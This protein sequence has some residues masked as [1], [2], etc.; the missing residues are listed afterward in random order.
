MVVPAA[1]TMKAATHTFETGCQLEMAEI[2]TVTTEH[3]QCLQPVQHR[4]AM[5]E[6]ADLCIACSSSN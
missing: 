2:V 1:Q 4:P 3:Q 6:V 5:N